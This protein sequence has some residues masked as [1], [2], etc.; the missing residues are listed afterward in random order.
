MLKRKLTIY[1]AIASNAFRSARGA[2]YERAKYYCAICVIEVILMIPKT[3]DNERIRGFMYVQ[4][5][6]Y[7]KIIPRKD[8]K[9]VDC[10]AKQFDEAEEKR[11]SFQL[12][13][14]KT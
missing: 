13:W 8:K 10:L 14:I 2:C 9:I 3:K 11:N 6:P 1:C 12:K 5:I 7:L 4:Q